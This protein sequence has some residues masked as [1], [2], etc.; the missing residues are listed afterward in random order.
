MRL[1][2][3][4][5]GDG[6]PLVNFPDRSP[7]EKC[8][9]AAG[10]LTEQQLDEARRGIGQKNDDAATDALPVGETISAISD[11][12]LADQ[13]VDLGELNV[14]QAKQLLDGQ[15]KFNLGPYAIIDSLGQGGMGQVFKARHKPTGHIVA[16]KVLPRSR[17]TPAAIASFKRE[18]SALASLNHPCL[19]RAL[20]AGHDGNV[21]Y[22]VCEYVPGGD[23]RKLVRRKGPLDMH[24]AADIIYQVAEGLQHAHQKGLVHRDVKPGNVLVTP[25]GKAKLSDLGLAGPL[26]DAAKKDPRYGKIVGTADYVAPDHIDSPW[27]PTAAWD[28]YSLGCT[29]YFAITGNV[30]FPGG[31]TSDKAR[32]HRELRPLDPRRIN[33]TL[34][35]P[36]VDVLADMVAKDPAK[37]I[38]SVSEV[39]NRLARWTRR[40]PDGEESSREDKVPL[41]APEPAADVELV[42]PP[43]IGTEEGPQTPLAD[44]ESLPPIL[45][46]PSPDAPR[47]DMGAF[48]QLALEPPPRPVEPPA[49]RLPWLLLATP[50]VLIV[51]A[52]LAW[53]FVG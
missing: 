39:M 23:L 16:I 15:T 41:P 13:L 34:D 28:V 22:L 42:P 7:F 44:S 25:Q 24:E 5:T 21:H 6:D 53:W 51:V 2:S 33:S 8:A 3:Y 52:I 48:P 10:L 31:S 17:S 11:K 27:D 20:D 32:A 12:E 4:V 43:E 35:D 40:S 18:I 36:F 37:R 30:P 29:L 14:W 49:K 9:L 26:E 46:Q 38:A 47:R 50:P 45:S 1:A 19:V